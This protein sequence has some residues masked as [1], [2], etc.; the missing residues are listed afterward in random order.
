VRWQ[1]RTRWLATR[2]RWLRVSLAIV[3][4]VLAA[5]FIVVAL[6]LGSVIFG[7]V[8][9]LAALVREM[10]REHPYGYNRSTAEKEG[11]TGMTITEMR[12]ARKN[13]EAVL[14]NN[15]RAFEAAT[16]LKVT[17]LTIFRESAQLKSG[18]ADLPARLLASVVT[19]VELD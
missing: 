7:Y 1:N 14:S 17:G 10:C 9:E 12:T 8:R 5:P 15:V 4:G 16:G 2:P 13:L 3:A 11:R 19:A 6:L 18:A